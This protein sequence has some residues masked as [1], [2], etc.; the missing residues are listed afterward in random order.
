M[1]AGHLVSRLV[2]AAL[3][4]LLL[5]L[6]PA[7]A[8]GQQTCQFRNHAPTPESTVAGA[9][10]QIAV[11]IAC[12]EPVGT[13]RVL[14]DGVE[15]AFQIAGPSPQERTVFFQPEAPLAVGPHTVAVEVLTDGRTSWTFTVAPTAVAPAGGGYAALRGPGP[16]TPPRLA[17]LAGVL[18]LLAAGSLAARRPARR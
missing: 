13:V 8:G 9:Q 10:P 5:A 16:L 14:L 1:D 3:G 7:G 6:V 18:G 2:P 4:L 12:T 17:L 11:I 15:V